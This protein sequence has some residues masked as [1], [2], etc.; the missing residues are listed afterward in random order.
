MRGEAIPDEPYQKEDL[1]IRPHVT[2]DV[3]PLYTKLLDL[4]KW[5]DN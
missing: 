1:Q 5:Q 2:M 3:L 4:I